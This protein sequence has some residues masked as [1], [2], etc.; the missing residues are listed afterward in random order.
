MFTISYAVYLFFVATALALL[1]IQIEGKN[2]WAKNL[3]CWRAKKP[4]NFAVRAYMFFMS[5]RE[6]TGYHLVM[7]TFVLL[8][9]HFPYFAGVGWSEKREVWT[10]SNYFLL[11][12]TWDFLWHV[13]NPY[14]G[15]RKFNPKA[16]SHT[17]K[18]VGSL[19]VPRDYVDGVGFSA[20]FAIIAGKSG[21]QWVTF[22]AVFVILTAVSCF[23]SLRLKKN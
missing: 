4:Y 22:F 15:I 17:Y 8:I 3:P 23:I 1:E 18:W 12:V 10:I 19:P 7:F 2:G 16:V 20:I 9:L 21:W 6:L 11:S 14:Y 13:W 5:G